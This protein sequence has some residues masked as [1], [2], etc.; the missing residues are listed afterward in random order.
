[1][2]NSQFERLIESLEELTKAVRLVANKVD[3][4]NDIITIHMEKHNDAMEKISGA[5]SD[6]SINTDQ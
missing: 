6:I 3:D 1:M 5:L 2:D 4:S